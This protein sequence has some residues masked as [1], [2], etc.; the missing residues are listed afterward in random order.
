MVDY[1]SLSQA[2]SK[3]CKSILKL[4]LD[5]YFRVKTRLDPLLTEELGF[6]LLK[7][8]FLSVNINK[9]NLQDFKL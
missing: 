2:G 4:L 3:G 5:Y 1:V 8:K 9:N 6:Y 7:K